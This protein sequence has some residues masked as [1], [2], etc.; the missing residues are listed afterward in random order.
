MKIPLLGVLAAGALIGRPAAAT[1]QEPAPP[2]LQVFLDCQAFG[3]DDDFIMT[4]LTWVSWVRDRQTADVHVLITDS[5]A[6]ADELDRLRAAGVEV[7]VA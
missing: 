7:V 1:G 4:E 3:C 2:P 5:S 6:P